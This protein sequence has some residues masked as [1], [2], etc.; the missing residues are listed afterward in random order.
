LPDVKTQFINGLYEIQRGYNFIEDTMIDNGKKDQPICPSGTFNKLIESMIGCHPSLEI[1]FI[2]KKCA[3]L[4]LPI[5]VTEEATKYLLQLS[6][7]TLPT[8]LGFALKIIRQLEKETVSCM[9]DL[10]QPQ[11]KER[12]F[13]DFGSLYFNDDNNI[14][15]NLL[16]EIG[17]DVELKDLLNIKNKILESISQKTLSEQKVGVTLF[18]VTNEKTTLNDVGR[19]Y[20]YHK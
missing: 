5:V 18:N 9:W 14:D 2:T 4:K 13:D 15:F 10:I 3:S 7:S 16:I 6:S 17:K 19:R 1:I 8:T 11:V 20:E 12:M